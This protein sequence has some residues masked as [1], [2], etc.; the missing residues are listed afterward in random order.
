MK[1]YN[2]MAT[3]YIRVLLLGMNPFNTITFLNLVERASNGSTQGHLSQRSLDLTSA[4]KVM[5]WIPSRWVLAKSCHIICGTLTNIRAKIR[6]NRRGFLTSGVIFLCD[7]TRCSQ[8]NEA[9]VRWIWL[10]NPVM[11]CH[12]A[13]SMSLALWK[14]TKASER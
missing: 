3:R 11:T 9:E 13:I 5:P 4:K 10:S 6:Q 7:N 8:Y 2:K 14:K 1:I 12:L